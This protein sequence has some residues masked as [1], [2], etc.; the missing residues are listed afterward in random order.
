MS[1]VIVTIS[2]EGPIH[3]YGGPW[4]RMS[5]AMSERRKM[6][7]A[8]RESYPDRDSVVMLVRKISIDPGKKE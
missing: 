8:D 4:E 6:L 7:A 1:Y 2:P 5:T 3:V